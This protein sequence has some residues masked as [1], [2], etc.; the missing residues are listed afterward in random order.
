MTFGEISR[1]RQ[2]MRGVDEI[3]KS[4]RVMFGVATSQRTCGVRQRY[5]F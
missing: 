3:V 2:W 5:A 4:Y 1:P